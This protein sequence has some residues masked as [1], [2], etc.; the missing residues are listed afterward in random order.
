[1]HKDL[2]NNNEK[3][4]CKNVNIICDIG[5]ICSFDRPE[6]DGRSS[7]R[8]LVVSKGFF[9]Y[10]KGATGGVYKPRGQTRGRGVAQ[11][12]TTLL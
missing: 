3:I 1:M 10:H 9:T 7:I 8:D 6:V 4:N 12:T 2:E 11:M 5:L